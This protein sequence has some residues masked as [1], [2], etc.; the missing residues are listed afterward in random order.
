MSQKETKEWGREKQGVRERDKESERK[1][2]DKN[3]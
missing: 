3:R 2:R 1:K